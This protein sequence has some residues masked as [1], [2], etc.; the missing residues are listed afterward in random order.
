[1]KPAMNALFWSLSLLITFLCI[2]IMWPDMLRYP[3]VYY[4]RAFHLIYQGFSRI[5][6]ALALAYV[7][8]A[9]ETSNGGPIHKFLTLKCWIPL[10][11]LSYSAFLVHLTVIFYFYTTQE[12]T[13]H[14]Q[15]QNMVYYYVAN[16]FFSYLC[17]FVLAVTV[18]L[19]FVGLERLIFKTRK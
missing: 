17:A 16:L 8:Y 4:T 1:M 10:S 9:C 19:P 5:A 15:D 6:W 18:E 13:L 7:I 3:D 12:H 2:F 11:R 14:I